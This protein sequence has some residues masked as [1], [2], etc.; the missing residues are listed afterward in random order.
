MTAPLP[1]PLAGCTLA[2]G[3]IPPALAPFAGRLDYQAHRLGL[4]RGDDDARPAGGLGF[5]LHTPFTSPVRCEWQSWGDGRGHVAGEML[6]QAAS[7][8]MAVHGRA[9][10]G[11]RPLGLDYVSTLAS[12]LALNGAMAGAVGQWRGGRFS[13]CDGSLF[14]AALLAVGQYLADDTAPD[15]TGLTPAGPGA[16]AA[17]PPFVSADGVRFELEA[18][19]AE[20]WLRFW[21]A[22]GVTVELA[23]QGWQTFLWR[24][25]RAVAAQ[26]APLLA[27]AAALPFARLRELAR[28]AGIALSPLRTLAERAGD[29]DEIELQRRGPWTF[30]YPPAPPATDRTSAPDRLPLDGVTVLESCRRIQGPLAGHLLAMLGAKVIRIE[31]P[32]GDA[33]RGMPPLSNGCSARFDALNRLKSVIEIDL[34]SAAGRAEI[35]AR[36]SE[37]DVFLH[38]WAPGKAAAFGLD[39]DDLLALKP[40]LVYGRAAGWD[41]DVSHGLPGTDFMAQA[42]T[43]V[44]DAIAPAPGGRGGTLFTALDV[45]GGAVAAQGI[46]AALFARLVGR[47]GARVRTSLAGAASLLCAG[48]VDQAGC[49]V[50]P[51]ADGLLALE[52]R[53]G[54]TLARL[55]SLLNGTPADGLAVLTRLLRTK[56]TD[57]WLPLLAAAGVPASRVVEDLALLPQDPR[58]RSLLTG[59]TCSQVNSPWRFVS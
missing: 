50:F 11:P 35:R 39:H 53:S 10:G 55:A 15:Q 57:D 37:A 36:V 13:R 2:L 49:G 18:L 5:S 54:D 28:T 29:A 59:A 14:A 7:G 6:L 12:V 30:A 44:A 45:L 27:A 1:C 3:E 8:L 23:G 24:Y 51:T 41:R 19:T 38:N 31:P 52:C 42:H 25:A 22:A 56:G 21:Q 26:P 40:T 47:S 32:G 9:S 34:K 4:R 48:A 16:A 46:T 33:L 43:G 20:P 17:H 58:A